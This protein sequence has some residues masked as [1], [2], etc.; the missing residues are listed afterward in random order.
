M[1]DRVSLQH[2]PTFTRGAG[3]NDY[4][5]FGNGDT[6]ERN[7]TPVL[8]TGDGPSKAIVSGPGAWHT[9]FLQVNA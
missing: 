5:Q 2:C 7:L 6:T 3:R 4:G 1:T 9:L 8:V